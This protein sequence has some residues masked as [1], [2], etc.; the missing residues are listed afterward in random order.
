MTSVNQDSKLNVAQQFNIGHSAAVDL[1][2]RFSFIPLTFNPAAYEI[3]KSRRVTMD[4]SLLS[5]R[6]VLLSFSLVMLK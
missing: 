2:S 5:V 6:T 4:D 3:K 1:L